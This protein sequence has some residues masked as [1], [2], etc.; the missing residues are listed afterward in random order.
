[1]SGA[2]RRLTVE[3][4]GDNKLKGA[5]N[6]AT[7]D[8]DKFDRALGGLKTGALAA[9]AG[10]A[11]V[12]TAAWSMANAAAEDE[13]AAAALAKTIANVTGATDGQIAATE[14]WIS[15]QG[16]QLGISDDQLR[17]A[18]DSL[19]KGTKDIAEAQKL[20]S[21]A[22]DISAGTGKDLTA[23]SDALAKAYNGQLGPLK[24]LDPALADL[25]KSGASADEVMAALGKT[26]EGQASAAAE[27]TAGKMQI[28]KLQFSELQ[29]EI[30]ARLI[31]VLG[32]LADFALEKVLPA[33]ETTVGWITE[34]WPAV[35]GAI[36]TGITAV[37]GAWDSYGAPT[38]AV[39]QE[40]IGTTIDV[41]VGAWNLFGDDITRIVSGS[42]GVVK[43]VVETI[44]G[45]VRAV[46]QT[47]TALISGDWS[48][49]WDGIKSYVTVTWDGIR[50]IVSGALDILKGVIGGALDGIKAVISGAWDT[51]RGGVSGA[52]DGIKSAVSGAI[53]GVKTVVSTGVDD[54]VGFFTGL[55]GRITETIGDV[56]AAA[57]GIGKEVIK[58]LG[59][60]LSGVVGFT[61]D[62][63]AAVAKAVKG[64]INAIIDK[65]NAAFEFKIGVPFG[66]DIHI[67][68]PD[69]PKLHTGGVFRAPG[70][71]SEGLALLETGES[72]FQP[73][74][75]AAL[76]AAGFN[77]GSGAPTELHVHLHMQPGAD[78]AEAGRQAWEALAAHARLNGIPTWLAE[79]IAA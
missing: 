24:K 10:L 39:I 51:I 71:R 54:M 17:P 45:Q 62:I 31:P 33:I 34:N 35:Q 7:N 3:I 38:L 5:T 43:T 4:L 29:E 32:A 37:R 1:M 41:I 78:M 59:E 56:G 55:P 13:K 70:G 79:G 47:V 30:G 9:G 64:A 2:T 16:R 8:V 77:R 23:V 69:I 74:Q 19:V 73:D 11:V 75:L 65:V 12:G 44:I 42:F 60:G 63:A 36:E 21:L 76:A 27:T 68:P 53:D 15:A 49:A 14:D 61:S 48:G 26:F 52:W 66:P 18:L 72:V 22:M 28:A 50:G 46:I 57:L 6:A 58:K 20:A 25:V 40:V 67:D